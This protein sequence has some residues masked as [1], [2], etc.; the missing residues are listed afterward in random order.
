MLELY[1]VAPFASD[2]GFANPGGLC[3]AVPRSQF[4][5]RGIFSK[6]LLHL[7][8]KTG[9]NRSRLSNAEADRISQHTQNRDGHKHH[10]PA[11]SVSTGLRI[12]LQCSS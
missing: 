9:N 5:P 2:L 8:M 1:V 10:K 3:M 4:V 12:A 6:Q 7:G 11:M